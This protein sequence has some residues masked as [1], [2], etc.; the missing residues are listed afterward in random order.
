[1]NPQKR[2]SW[3]WRTDL[4]LPRGRGKEVMDW[5]FGVN[6]CK[7]LPLEWINNG[8]LLYS[9]G[10]CGH[11][12]WS[13]IMWEKRMYTCMCEWVIL[14][15]SRKLREHCK[16]AIMEKIK[17]I[18]KIKYLDVFYSSLIAFAYCDNLWLYI[19][20]RNLLG[21]VLVCKSLWVSEKLQCM[22]LI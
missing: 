3:T 13:M 5:E 4:W 9:T 20:Y 10:N 11:L 12:W 18:I 8:I 16:S 15:C 17:I 6:R 7:L 2:K 1:M 22:K 14:L 21:S 19:F